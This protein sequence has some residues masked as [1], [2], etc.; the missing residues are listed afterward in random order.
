MKSESRN[1]NVATP[2]RPVGEPEAFREYA[3]LMFDLQVLAFQADIARVSTFMMARE[4]I[5]R[6]YPEI[7][8]PEAH[9]S[10]SHHGNN[11]EKMKA[12]SK[13]NTYHV[14]TLAYFVRKLQAIPDGDGTLLDHSVV[15]YG[16]GMSDGNVH[17]NYNVPVVVV[18]GR[19]LHLKGNRHLRYPKGTPLA[20]LSLTLMAKFGVPAESFGDSTGKFDNLLSDV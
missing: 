1:R 6:S 8:L 10:M 16:S 11:P 14:D 3:E 17:N 7:G 4:N 12:F 20:N 2:E 18:G 13:L 5:N 9:H 19:D 15:L